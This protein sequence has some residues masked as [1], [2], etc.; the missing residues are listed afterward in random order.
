MRTY[1]AVIDGDE[2]PADVNLK[3]I[4][5]ART[6]DIL[7]YDTYE[8]ALDASTSDDVILELSPIKAYH[9]E[10]SKSGTPMSLGAP[11]TKSTKKK[12]K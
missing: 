5:E 7:L 3:D 2:L 1:F 6:D 11:K 9:V 10:T 12:G 4:E 8:D